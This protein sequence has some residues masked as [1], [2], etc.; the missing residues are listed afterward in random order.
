MFAKQAL[1][2]NMS[3]IETS[4]I[5]MTISL[6]LAGVGTHDWNELTRSEKYDRLEGLVGDTAIVPVANLRSARVFTK[7][8]TENPSGSH[9][10]RAFVATLRNFEEE[11]LIRPGDEVRD[12]TS[13]SGGISLAVVAQVLGYMTRITVPDELPKNRLFPMRFFGA[14]IVQAGTGYIR[15]ASDF[16]AEE[17]RALKAD[18]AWQLSR[19]SDREQR[20]YVFTNK[21]EDRRI[22]YINHSENL[23]SP[24]A[25]STI[26][27]E[28]VHQM[29][30]APDAVIL[31]MGNW[32]TIAGISPTVR[33][34]WPLTRIIG[35]EGE[36]TEVHD[37][38]GTSVAG[39]PLRF[40]DPLLLDEA[41]IVTDQQRDNANW[42]INSP[43]PLHERVGHSSLMGLVVADEFTHDDYTKSALTITYDQQIRY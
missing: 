22:C 3:P 12:I 25:F 20:A 30:D 10:D 26:G 32:T 42:A 4:C 31:A 24:R 21:G 38:F 13:G 28:I 8:E 39:I 19:P 5:D 41:M 7:L 16:Q 36:N 17:I 1:I 9:Y 15:Q 14:E 43:R 18:P 34:A 2:E 6:G 11:G 29:V 40:R 27:R 37:N 33:A 35:Y 23:L